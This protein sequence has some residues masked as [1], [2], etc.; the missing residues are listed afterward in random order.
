MRLLP[1]FTVGPLGAGFRI[2]GV[3]VG[4]RHR[5]GRLYPA[6]AVRHRGSDTGATR[7][8]LRQSVRGAAIHAAFVAFRL[9]G[10]GWHKHCS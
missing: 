1:L 2:E 10:E 9:E 8:S 7:G 4:G 6:G 3:V 5:V